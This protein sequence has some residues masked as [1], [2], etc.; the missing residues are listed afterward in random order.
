M[1]Y[2]SLHVFSCLLNLAVT[3]FDA[4]SKFN[5]AA[6]SRVDEAGI[7]LMSSLNNYTQQIL[8]VFGVGSLHSLDLNTLLGIWL[9]CGRKAPPT[10]RNLLQLIRQLHLDDLAQQV[11]AYLCGERVKKPLDE[12]MR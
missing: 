10:W 3:S 1:Y 9:S 7:P 6:L 11:E 12:G 2:D 4:D 8:T 5:M